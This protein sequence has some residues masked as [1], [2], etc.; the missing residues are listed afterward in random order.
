MLT[1]YGGVDLFWIGLSLFLLAMSKGGFPVG[2]IALPLLIL[3]WPEQGATARSAVGF[4]LPMLCLMDLVAM[5][6]YGRR[7]DWHQL[8]ML[9]PA[10]VAGVAV[11]AVLFVSSET[12]LLAVSDRMLKLLIGLLGILFVLYFAAKRWIL[13]RL[14]A[15]KPTW[16]SGSVFGFAAGVTSTMAHAAGPVMQMYLLPQQLDKKVFAATG[17]AFFWMMNLVKLLPFAWMGR[18]EESHLRL[19]LVLL[20]VLPLGVAVGWW[21]THRTEQTHYVRLI[22]AVLLFTSITLIVKA[23]G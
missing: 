15:S 3:V 2:T 19:G 13:K 8:R 17:C 20:P 11:G 12:A 9:V 22:Y 16:L 14:E 6:F 7:V 1:E 21:L 4:M 10:M 18:L 5:A 23:L